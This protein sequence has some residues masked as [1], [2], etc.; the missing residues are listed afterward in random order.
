MNFEDVQIVYQINNV[1]KI[2]KD[3]TIAM[4]RIINVKGVIKASNHYKCVNVM[5][6]DLLD[7][8]HCKDTA[9]AHQIQILRPGSN[10]I[11]IVL[12]N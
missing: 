10:R 7:E 12:W 11:P 8:Q 4:F 3:A 6:D 2:T 5:T 9:V 1:V